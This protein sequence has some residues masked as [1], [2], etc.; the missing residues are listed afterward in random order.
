MPQGN[1]IDPRCRGFD[2]HKNS[3]FALRD[4]HKQEDQRPD[5][6]FKCE[7]PYN[8]CH[9][10]KDMWRVGL[11]CNMIQLIDVQKIGLL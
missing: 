6:S 11:E 5:L 4:L 2:G 7:I 8:F 3:M 10:G 9:G 1:T